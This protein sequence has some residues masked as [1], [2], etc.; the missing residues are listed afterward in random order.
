MTMLS[1]HRRE[2]LS[3]TAAPLVA[4]AAPLE[5]SG[6]VVR[7]RGA[8][9]TWEWS[10]VTDEFRLLDSRGRLVTSGP[11]QPLVLVRATAG[12]PARCAA[13]KL[14]RKTI[15]LDRLEVIYQGVNGAGTLTVVWRFDDGACW[16]DP[17]VY[18][19]PTAGDIVD[20][21]CFAKP[22]GNSARTALSNNYL[23]FPGISEGSALSPIIPS[24]MGLNMVGWLGHGGPIDKPG[25]HQQWG[26]PCHFFGGLHRGPAALPIK[27]SMRELLSDAF[28]CGLADL[29][30]ANLFLETRGGRHCLIFEY[31]GDLWGQLR[32]PGR[33]TL[34]ATL[35]WTVAADYRE[36]IRAYYLVLVRAGIV[37][38]K[39]NSAA[40]IAAVLAPQFN[41]WGAQ[42]V[43]GKITARFDEGFLRD[44]Y[45]QMK[46]S[47]MKPGM[48]VLDDK[49]EGRYGRLEHS[50][51][52][53]PH[54]EEFLA[55]V[56]KDGLRVGMWAAF[57]RCQDPAEFGLTLDHMLRSADGTPIR[58][59]G[60]DG[61]YLFDVTQPKVQG[62]LRG[63]AKRFI[64]RYRP[65]LVKFDFG[66][67]LPGLSTGAPRDMR[68]A[69]E[70]LLQKGV[71]VVVGAMKEERP[72]LVVMYYSLSPLLAAHIDLHSPDD[73][74][75][76]AAEYDLEAN[77]R[78]FFSSLLGELGIPTYSSSGYDWATAPQ[79][80]F[81]AAAIGT[82]G[83][84]N[85]FTPDERSETPTPLQ[86]AK[87]NGLARIL[88][89]TAVFTVR[90]IGPLSLGPTRGAH[91]SSWVRLEG[92][93]VVLLA[94][95][96]HGLISGDG[97][98][99]YRDI[100]VS[101]AQVVIASL[102]QDG[103][104][105]ASA[106]GVVPYGTGELSLRRENAS[107]SHAVVT[108]H[109]FGGGAATIHV[110]LRDGKLN[111]NLREHTT[112]GAPIEW[113]AVTVE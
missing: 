96:P 75:M 8:N 104:A 82:L 13:G 40:K 10:P 74:F 90:P 15:A 25:L 63:L 42:W 64:R 21:R 107:S 28:C 89:P 53:F 26:L 112:D 62:V 59:G 2:F 30:A 37:F 5:E 46:A 84:L 51:E 73:L 49:W 17:I 55:G 14:S 91:A 31:R 65:D 20:V 105:R 78:F 35:C 86:L 39:K 72:D 110:P 38:P 4:L 99:G 69:G 50:A 54:F 101:T 33:F 6:G 71:E 68:W 103:L 3:L 56:R 32:A 43:A 22:E 108:E 92:G 34:G 12:G 7:A 18:E 24:S 111:L 58:R 85:S 57:L 1:I 70:R 47:G 36:A 52:R 102:T 113:I 48:L 44:L 81:D 80:W 29:P 98:P 97:V 79:I 100:A 66:Y 41:T 45:Q 23:L 93:E 9:Y 67:E 95:R 77:R 76:C 83:S 106:L 94:L 60:S 61:Y 16:Q 87:Y 11:L 27:G 88:R 19:D 109:L